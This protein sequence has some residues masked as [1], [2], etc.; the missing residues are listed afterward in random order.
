MNE[1]RDQSVFHVARELIVQSDKNELHPIE[2]QKLCFFSFAWFAHLTGQK[3]YPEQTWAM[4]HGPVVGDLL[5]AHSKQTSVSVSEIDQVL[6][7]WKLDHSFHNTYAKQIIQTVYEGYSQLNFWELRELSHAEDLWKSA[8]EQRG[9]A[10]RARMDSDVMVEYYLSHSPHTSGVLENGKSYVL[11][12]SL[13]DPLVIVA[14]GDILAEVEERQPR[15]HSGFVERL[16]K[17]AA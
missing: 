6:D 9:T 16:R 1:V 15:P 14:D 8:W 10:A 11:Q 7:E 3:L 2:L 13:P 4:R 12:L 5:S 17:L